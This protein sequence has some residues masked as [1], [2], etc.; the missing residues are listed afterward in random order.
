MKLLL[1][2]AALAC[3]VG[4]TT[5]HAS[6][7]IAVIAV[8]DKVTFDNP[9]A[10]TTIQISGVFKVAMEVGDHYTEAQKGV[11]YMTM[12]SYVTAEIIRREWFDLKALAGTRQVV[13]F[14]SARAAMV[15]IRKSDKD[16]KEP[17]TYPTGNGMARVPADQPI[18]K[19][20]LAVKGD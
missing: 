12:P 16:V 6:G 4:L 2:V 10:P 15:R 1:A 3:S 9:E 13:A 19:E 7:P 17:D 11:L 20:I 5:V 8:I 14:G 18:A